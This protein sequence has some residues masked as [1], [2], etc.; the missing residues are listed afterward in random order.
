MFHGQGGGTDDEKDWLSQYFLQIDRNLQKVLSHDQAPLVLA[1]VDF[2]FPIYRGINSYNYLMDKGVEGNPEILKPE[3]L[4]QHAWEVV[5]P[6]FA[7]AQQDEVEKFNRE[8]G[9]GHASNNVEEIVRAT[10]NGR[11]DSLFVTIGKQVWGFYNPRSEEVHVH[12]KVEAGDDDLLDV[13]AIQ[14]ILHGGTVFAVKEDEIPGG[15]MIA[16]NFR[17]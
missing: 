10:A 6:Y 3:E 15:S 5:E 14:T 13:A 17:Y 8:F 12:E 4:Q 2:L 9:T 11:V 7:N 16:A 1:G